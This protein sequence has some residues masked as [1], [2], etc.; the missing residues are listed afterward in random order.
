MKIFKIIVVLALLYFTYKG[1][2]AF[3]NFEIGTT[4]QVAKIEEAAGIEKKGEVIALLMFLGE[5][6]VV[7]EHYY[8]ENRKKCLS[9][10]TNAEENSNAH[11]ECAK[12]NAVLTGKK[13]VSIVKILLLSYINL[14]F[15]I[16]LQY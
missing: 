10:K 3:K 8:T 13:I 12:V 5:P 2:V 6:P 4:N 11:Y 1:V 9:L 14:K 7:V 16:F 15:L